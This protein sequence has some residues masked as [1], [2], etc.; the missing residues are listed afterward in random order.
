MPKSKAK[1][2]VAKSTGIV[3]GE[4]T[5]FDGHAFKQMDDNEIVQVTPLNKDLA[6]VSISKYQG[7]T[8]LD[9]RRFYL[10]ADSEEWCPTSKGIRIPAD[11]A[12]TFLSDLQGAD[13]RLAPRLND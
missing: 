10:S 1:G 6:V 2:A 9:V 8:S 12:V 11:A 7:K 13:V 4:I 3:G 5:E